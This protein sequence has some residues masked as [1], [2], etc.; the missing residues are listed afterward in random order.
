MPSF[1]QSTWP[2]S[3]CVVTV[4]VRLARSWPPRR[5]TVRRCVLGTHS[6]G[7]HMSNSVYP[8]SGGWVASTMARWFQSKRR[9]TV[10]H[11]SCHTQTQTTWVSFTRQRGQMSNTEKRYINAEATSLRVEGEERAAGGES[12]KLVGY[13]ARY[14][15]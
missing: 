13:A 12:P 10:R 14:N 4:P 8:T 6:R 5:Q 2:T 1:S 9:L 3:C 7:V 11:G 15:S